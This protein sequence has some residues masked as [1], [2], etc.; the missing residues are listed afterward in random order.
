MNVSKICLINHCKQLVIT[1]YKSGRVEEKKVNFD[2]NAAVIAQALKPV[3]PENQMSCLI[4][5]LQLIES[6]RY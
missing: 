3:T 4:A 6:F 1:A 5:V 2:L